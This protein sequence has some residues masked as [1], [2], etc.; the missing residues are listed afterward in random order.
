M[1]KNSNYEQF[2]LKGDG[3]YRG[4]DTS[5]APL[6]GFRDA[7]CTNGDKA[8]YTLY[9]GCTD[10]DN[11]Q[12]VPGGGAFW[13]PREAAEGSS[14]NTPSFQIVPVDSNLNYCDLTNLTGY[15][16]TSSCNQTQ[17]LLL[18]GIY[19]ANTYTFCNGVKNP[20]DMV[21]ISV[22]GGPGTGDIFYFMK[23]YGM[24]A[25]EAPGFEAGL[26]S[27]DT[28]GDLGGNSS[29]CQ[30]PAGRGTPGPRAIVGR[31]TSS[32]ITYK[33]GSAFSNQPV[34]DVT[35]CGYHGTSKYENGEIGP[36]VY[37]FYGS[38]TTDKN[39][40]FRLESNYEPGKHYSKG[41]IQDADIIVAYTGLDYQEALII[42]M[43]YTMEDLKVDS[44]DSNLY[45]NLDRSKALIPLDDI[46]TD[47]EVKVTPATFPGDNAADDKCP[48]EALYVNRSVAERTSCQ[49]P[50]VDQW[51]NQAARGVDN[52]IQRLMTRIDLAFHGDNQYD[53][54]SDKMTNGQYDYTDLDTLEQYNVPTSG[55]TTD[56]EAI[57]EGRLSTRQTCMALEEMRAAICKVIGC[58]KLTDQPK[59][60]T[61][62]I[63]AEMSNC[64]DIK[65]Y[66]ND[67]ESL[68]PR[69]LGLHLA[70][71]SYYI[72]RASS[73]IDYNSMYFWY[74]F[75]MNVRTMPYCWMEDN[76]VVLFGE[77]EPYDNW[78][79]PGDNKTYKLNSEYFDPRY[80]YLTDG[81]EAG[82]DTY[83]KDN[84]YPIPEGNNHMNTKAFITADDGEYYDPNNIWDPT[85]CEGAVEN[86]AGELIDPET[87]RTIDPEMCIDNGRLGWKNENVSEMPP[88]S[89]SH[90]GVD[91][92]SAT[93]NLYD[94][95]DMPNI[96]P[97]TDYLSP[98]IYVNE[99]NI[100]Q[101]RTAG[102]GII[103]Q[104]S[105]SSFNYSQT[106]Y[107]IG[108]QDMLCTFSSL[109]GHRN[110]PVSNGYLQI[111]REVIDDNYD[112]GGWS[113][114]YYKYKPEDRQGNAESPDVNE[115]FA[116]QISQ[117]SLLGEIVNFIR[118]TWST[119][120]VWAANYFE[121]DN[122]CINFTETRIDGDTCPITIRSLLLG[123]DYD[124]C[125]C[126][127]EP[128][129]EECN[130]G[131]PGCTCSYDPY[132][133]PIRCER[134]TFPTHCYVRDYG[135]Y[136]EPDGCN[137]E[138]LKFEEHV[139][140]NEMKIK[141]RN[142]MMGIN[143]FTRLLS[144]PSYAEAAVMTMR[145]YCADTFAT[146]SEIQLEDGTTPQGMGTVDMLGPGGDVAELGK[147]VGDPR[148]GNL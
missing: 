54:K 144:S 81:N 9:S 34:E 85:V 126:R 14:W 76:S 47:S 84:S 99:S 106:R 60:S 107:R 114:A 89:Y 140:V 6:P 12:E 10:F 82:I 110:W 26:A 70:S 69:G 2:F 131:E 71:P 139:N 75:N 37:G 138:P 48:K 147:L 52:G 4:L 124:A 1:Y 88:Y 78:K 148:F 42:P 115:L 61:Q 112:L 116:W 125:T 32:K 35:I 145:M 90:Q 136:G 5:W 44:Y 63:D 20:E 137:K 30:T 8:S 101:E 102:A 146:S 123:A 117:T 128:D 38:T 36:G 65:A 72:E 120:T 108:V 49:P 74:N 23:G 132:G 11:G 98:P 127:T 31:V 83:A 64:E 59:D 133:E 22:T 19:E 40:V 33:D 7:T 73:L 66:L 16:G 95:K 29:L 143:Y 53:D 79:K 86:E 28:E 118:D 57:P 122:G 56:L 94:K 13:A 58:K 55:K 93:A 103:D 17:S 80:V 105:L 135:Q 97:P 130:E 134:Q 96:A 41:S 24:V 67:M 45:G 25:F 21:K 87:R 141:S 51:I 18:S 50:P 92:I 68:K 43:A 39:G 119:F 109:D 27:T 104:S 121:P 142:N 15:S 113:E 100:A 77:V 111:P 3:Y 91:Q 62:S 129:W 46:Q